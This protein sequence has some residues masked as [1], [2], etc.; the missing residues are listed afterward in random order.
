[1]SANDIINY[2]VSS[3]P[4]ALLFLVAAYSLKAVI[5]VIPGPVLY[6]AAGIL[7]PAKWAIV[8]TFLCLSLELTIGYI[9]GKRLGKGK[10]NKLLT[11][12]RYIAALFE[13]RKDNLPYL[14]FISRVLPLHVDVVSMF[15]GAVKMPF[16]S[17]LFI[18]LLGKSP[19]VIPYILAGAAITSPL[20]PEFLI[21]FAIS[22][23][24]TVSVFAFSIFL[25]KRRKRTLTLAAHL[26][27]NH[28]MQ[29]S[30]H[31]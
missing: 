28:L 26:S 18:S 7:F 8:I 23:I 14:C 31:D 5:M 17:H 16:G 30:I 29:D 1:M 3:I 13:E 12:N 25:Q 9:N 24:I 11:K 27:P 4:L 10:V 20:T 15:F 6:V 19:V 21:P 2:G 22:L